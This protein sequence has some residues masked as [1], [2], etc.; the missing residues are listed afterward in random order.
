MRPVY[1]RLLLSA[2]EFSLSHLSGGGEITT[3]GTRDGEPAGRTYYFI[4]HIIS[5]E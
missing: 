4:F 2:I 3:L 5:R 1:I